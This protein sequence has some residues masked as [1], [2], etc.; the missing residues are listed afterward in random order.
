MGICQHLALLSVHSLALSL[1]F[2][3]QSPSLRRSSPFKLS[4][5]VNSE[6]ATSVARKISAA[7]LHQFQTNDSV[8]LRKILKENDLIASALGI[9]AC[10]LECSAVRIADNEKSAESISFP[11]RITVYF[12]ESDEETILAG[13]GSLGVGDAWIGISSSEQFNTV[14]SIEKKLLVEAC[15]PDDADFVDP[16]YGTKGE[17]PTTVV[18]LDRH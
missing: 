6:I 16:L 12:A 2:R 18:N 15:E 17:T 13:G 5:T 10:L 11:I 3:T 1:A 4:L 14:G 8:I 7:H 9:G